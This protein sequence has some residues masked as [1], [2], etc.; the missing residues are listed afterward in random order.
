MTLI[1]FLRWYLTHS[2]LHPSNVYPS[3]KI[4]KKITLSIFSALLKSHIGIWVKNSENAPISS[5]LKNA[6]CSTV[7][8]HNFW[9]GHQA[10]YKLHFHPLQPNNSLDR[11]PSRITEPHTRESI[12]HAVST[13]H[14]PQLLFSWPTKL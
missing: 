8:L 12:Y 2:F 9:S 6:S 3:I 10:H 5:K 7:C 1:L 4:R 13:V 14:Q 11:R